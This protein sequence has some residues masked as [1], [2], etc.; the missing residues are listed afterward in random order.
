M[1]RGVY[2]ALGNWCRECA[3][4]LFC[5]LLISLA[6]LT[7]TVEC[8]IVNILLIF[9]YM[10]GL[11]LN[12]SNYRWGIYYRL[13]YLKLTFVISVLTTDLICLNDLFHIFN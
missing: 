12:D 9:G 4:N 8:Q 3:F 2:L 7:L 1:S 11:S 10:N 13:F 5:S 6:E